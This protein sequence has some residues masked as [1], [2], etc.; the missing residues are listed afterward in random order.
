MQVHII[1]NVAIVVGRKNFTENEYYYMFN[2]LEHDNQEATIN[3]TQ[4]Q[5]DKRY[6]RFM[7]NM[8]LHFMPD[9]EQCQ[10]QLEKLLYYN[11]L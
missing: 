3:D 5:K 6:S 7:R 11:N 2:H 9:D 4:E 8:I 1:T 10:I